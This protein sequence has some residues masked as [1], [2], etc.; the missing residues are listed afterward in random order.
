MKL[1]K[2]NSKNSDN[3]KNIMKEEKPI[4]ILYYAEW[5]PHCQIFKPV[6]KDVQDNLKS[7]KNVRIAEV[8]YKDLS[9]LPKKYKEIMGFPTLRV[10][11]GGKI[12]GEYN[13]LRTKDNIVKYV[14][15]FV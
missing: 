8:E 7:N 1:I 13:G 5:C 2:L 3:F 9:S 15:K 11:K 14:N 4:L 10:I 12:I 6:W